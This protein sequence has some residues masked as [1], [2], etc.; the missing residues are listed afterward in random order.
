M[1]DVERWLPLVKKLAR[2]HAPPHDFDD[3]VVDGLMA[4]WLSHDTYIDTGHGGS[5][6]GW[7]TVKVRW[8]IIDGSRIRTGW[9]RFPHVEVLTFEGRP[10]TSGNRCDDP[11]VRA[12]TADLIRWARTKLC[13]DDVELYDAILSGMTS[14]AYADKVGVT[15]GRICQRLA[16]IRELLNK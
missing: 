12:V 3:A 1:T 5:L 8:A 15:E 14:R 7:L 10:E 4:V 2:R 13:A 9:R 6:Q 11:E 16:K